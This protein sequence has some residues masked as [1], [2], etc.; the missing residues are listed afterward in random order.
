MVHLDFWCVDANFKCSL[1]DHSLW[2]SGH[3]VGKQRTS[4]FLPTLIWSTSCV[5]VP[6][7]DRTIAITNTGGRG[8]LNRRR[9]LGRRGLLGERGLLCGRGLF[10]EKALLGGGGGGGG[11]LR[12][13]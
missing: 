12:P 5:I 8:L 13:T 6:A 10:C 1:K 11:V 7:P 9:L 3:N 4:T 2:K